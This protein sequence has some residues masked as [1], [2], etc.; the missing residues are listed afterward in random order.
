M[1]KTNLTIQLEAKTILRA[2]AMAAVRG[3]SVS[4]LVAKT[5]ESMV[6][7]HDRYEAARRQAEQLMAE[8]EPHDTPPWTRDELYDR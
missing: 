8:A 7:E 1:A 2:K 3:T 6:D 5:L 4:A